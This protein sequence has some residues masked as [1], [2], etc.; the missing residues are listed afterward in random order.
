MS[1]SIHSSFCLC[2]GRKAARESQ[3]HSYQPSGNS[4]LCFSAVEKGLEPSARNQITRDRQPS[5]PS[6]CLHQAGHRNQ[7][8]P[9]LPLG[10]VSRERCSAEAKA[11]RA[12]ISCTGLNL[13]F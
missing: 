8:L 3:A 13:R 7:S 5:K 11:F 9:L 10:C 1:P 2:A 12:Q 6:R 4:L